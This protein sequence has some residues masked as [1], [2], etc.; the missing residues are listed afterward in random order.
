M[1]DEAHVLEG[2]FGSNFAY[3]FPRLGV[4]RFPAQ[5]KGRRTDLQVIAASATI[6]SPDQHLHASTGLQFDT[7]GEGD[8][9]AP[10]HERSV[11]HLA[12]ADRQ[13]AD[14]AELIHKALVER[15]TNGSFI[16]FVDSRQGAERLAVRTGYDSVV[17]PYRG[18]CEAEDRWEIE[19]ALRD[20]ILR[21]VVSTSALEF[22]IGVPH[23]NVGLNIG[24]PVTR[25]RSGRGW[26]ARGATV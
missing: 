8:D 16:T 24:V 14:M 21:G 15:A 1:I 11:L 7:V 9:G 6:S 20:G 17:K 10:R 19:R 5:G 26:V 18:G 12:A 13:E 3:V 4:A 23:F 2:V 22:G 25:S